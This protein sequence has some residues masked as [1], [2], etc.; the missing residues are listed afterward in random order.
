MPGVGR[1]RTQQEWGQGPRGSNQR[2]GCGRET[3]VC[4]R[5]HRRRRRKLGNTGNP[6]TSPLLGPRT[7]TW[8]DPSPE[9]RVVPLLAQRPSASQPRDAYPS[10]VVGSR[11]EQD[12]MQINPT[13]CSL[14]QNDK[15]EKKKSVSLCAGDCCQNGHGSA[16][17]RRKGKTARVT[18]QERGARAAP[19]GLGG[20]RRHRD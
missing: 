1:R 16:A 2:E 14:A 7:G 8:E 13:G 12:F 20:S 19:S 17:G 5:K 18:R 4:T 15:L 10:T 9:V 11:F 6:K 3:E